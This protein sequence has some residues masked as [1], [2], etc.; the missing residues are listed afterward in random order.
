M[1]LACTASIGFDGNMA[2]EISRQIKCLV[3]SSTDKNSNAHMLA[4]S[5]GHQLIGLRP[6]IYAFVRVKTLF[7]HLIHVGAERAPT[8]QVLCYA[9]RN[10]APNSI[11]DA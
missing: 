2:K 6:R 4:C 7:P 11:L 5:E 8:L 9:G 10:L 3:N 1:V